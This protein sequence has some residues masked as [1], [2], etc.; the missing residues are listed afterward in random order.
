MRLEHHAEVLC[1]AG[2]PR[3]SSGDTVVILRL[4][5]Y[6]EVNKV[7]MECVYRSKPFHEEGKPISGYRK[8][9]FKEWR[10]KGNFESTEQR[11]CDQ[12]RAIRKNGWLLE[13]ELE[14]IKRQI[15]DESQGEL[16]REQDVTVDA[17]TV[18]ID[19]RTVEEEINDAEDSIG[20]AEGDL[21]EEHQAIVEQLKKIMV[22]AR[23]GDSIMFKKVGKKV[24]EGSNR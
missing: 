18:E 22:E 12:T 11:V 9:M 24:F 15:E 23:T 7:V 17:E 3:H 10:E 16:C 1:P 6:K 4:I 20:D 2:I 21:S 14:A 8:R 5:P 13:L 19:A